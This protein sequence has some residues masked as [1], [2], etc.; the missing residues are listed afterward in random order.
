MLK[1]IYRQFLSRC[2]VQAGQRGNVV[3]RDDTNLLN[4]LCNLS[5]RSVATNDCVNIESV[6]LDHVVRTVM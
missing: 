1:A 6:S 4:K 2:D 3:A 5:L